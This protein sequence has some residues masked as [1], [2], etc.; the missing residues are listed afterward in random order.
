MLYDHEAEQC[1]ERAWG[2]RSLS[3][4]LLFWFQPTGNLW[5]WPVSAEVQTP[6]SKNQ[7]FDST[8]YLS[9]TEIYEVLFSHASLMS[10]SPAHLP[11]HLQPMVKIQ[12]N[13]FETI[14]IL[15]QNNDSGAATVMLFYAPRPS[16]R[17]IPK[18]FFHRHQRAL[19]WRDD[20]VSGDRGCRREYSVAVANDAVSLW[21]T[22]LLASYRVHRGVS[23]L[24]GWLLCASSSL[25]RR[26]KNGKKKTERKCKAGVALCTGEED[27]NQTW[28]NRIFS[29][30][31]S[32]LKKLDL[33]FLLDSD[34]FTQKMGHPFFFNLSVYEKY[35]HI[36]LYTGL[37][38]NYDFIIIFASGIKVY[39]WSKIA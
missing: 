29:I 6:G 13:Y 14:C 35:I 5:V 10:F 24:D 3:S 23:V 28:I 18:S 33:W 36:T 39:F 31:N 12:S 15:F 1:T 8:A 30:L 27:I 26:K 2:E 16:E 11:G 22:H 17:S 37:L 32:T 21:A 19:L 4:R 38:A 20:G 25:V 7:L 34:N 9:Q